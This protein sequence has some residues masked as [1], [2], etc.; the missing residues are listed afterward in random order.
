MENRRYYLRFLARRLD[1]II[2][3]SRIFEVIFISRHLKRQS[4]LKVRANG[5]KVEYV[6]RGFTFRMFNWEAP[7]ANF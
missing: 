5:I 6:N 3:F 1:D 2:N 7:C 4:E